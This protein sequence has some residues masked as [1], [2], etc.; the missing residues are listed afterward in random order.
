MANTSSC[1]GPQ[2][3][4]PLV[5]PSYLC[6]FPCCVSGLAFWNC[7]HR[8]KTQKR[9]K[10]RVLIR[11]NR[12]KCANFRG[13]LLFRNAGIQLC[14]RFLNSIVSIVLT[15]RERLAYSINY[16]VCCIGFFVKYL[17]RGVVN[18]KRLL[19]FN[20]LCWGWLT[21]RSIEVCVQPWYNPVWW[22]VSKHQLA[23]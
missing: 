15:Y 2:N 16:D 8:S 21:R 14:F 1:V 5:D 12:T 11:W 6:R 17:N 20:D 18:K 19:W 7:E 10:E 4:I 3:T 13:S 9:L 23:N 22:L